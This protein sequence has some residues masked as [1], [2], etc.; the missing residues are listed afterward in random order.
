MSEIEFEKGLKAE[1]TNIPGMLVFDLPVHGDSR[2]WFKENWQRAKQTGLGLP[3]LGPVQNNISFNA[4]RGVTRGIHAEPWDKYISVATG[5][6]FGAWVDLRPGK[7]F[8]E[9]YT[10]VIDPSKAVYVP[11]GVGNSFQALE[12]G[13][14]YTYLVNAHWSAE[15]KKTYT[16][17]NLADSQLGIDWPIPLDECE[18]SEADKAHPMLKDAIPMA[19]RRTL[20]TGAN[21]QLGRAVRKLAE[22]RGIA[23]S[24]DFGDR[25]EFDFSDPA[26]YSKVD[27]T[28]YGTV[29][30]CGA[31]TAVDAAEAPE[32]R[33]AAWAA[34]AQGPAL[35]AKACA[36]HGIALVHVSSDYVFDGTKE[37]HGE[38][39]PFSPLGVYGQTKA[40][41]DIAVANCPKHY[42]VRSSWV[43]G[44]GKNFVRTMA[45]L[46]DRCADPNDAL[47]E[48]TV[49]DDQF[50]RLTFT[51]D[52]AEGIFWLLGYRVGDREPSAP[53]E[54]G[55]YN[56]T[57]SGRVASWADI[58][59]K[60]FD[61][62]NGNAAAVKP[63]TTAEYYASAKGPISPRPAHS[64]LDLT[65]LETA[66]F[67]PHDWGEELSDYLQ[68]FSEQTLEV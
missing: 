68:E 26:D 31:Y 35:L 3:D 58:A 11:R 21:G 6:V 5:S 13:T 59:A 18:L 49:V 9:V 47:D 22:E 23:D 37:E 14:A 16:F 8:G 42:I 66:G 29:I 45:A 55:T 25:D 48:V 65:R 19:P 4:E 32:G 38:D 56:L 28:L 17:V 15:L 50:G 61:L 2:G 62:R 53:C 7:S 12:D 43:I 30:N 57:D 51:C 67:A 20:V 54:Y 24:F 41:G 10:C 44:D 40:A 46:S 1:R 39:E 64:A 33:A 63:V 27:W 34:N 36:E 52:M 60:V